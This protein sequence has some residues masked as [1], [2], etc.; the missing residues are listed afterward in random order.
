MTDTKVSPN[1]KSMTPSMIIFCPPSPRELKHR[2]RS[3]GNEPW[4]P[5]TSLA[6]ANV[7][8]VGKFATI[9]QSEKSGVPASRSE[10]QARIV[11]CGASL[12]KFDPEKKP[13][14]S[15]VHP[16]RVNAARDLERHET[17]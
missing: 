7:D 10:T 3:T 2:T 17:A 4:R 12:V 8:P 13:Q 16:A 11:R 6:A 5:R 15:G 1:H 14:E 9:G